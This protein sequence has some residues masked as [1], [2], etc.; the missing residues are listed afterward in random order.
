M[1]PMGDALMPVPTRA[2]YEL[3]RL[4]HRERVLM[5]DMRSKIEQGNRA[6]WK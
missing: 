4:E 1:H 5:G 6:R 2:Q 3:M